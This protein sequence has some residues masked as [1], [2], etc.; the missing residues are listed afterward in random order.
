MKRFYLTESQIENAFI[1]GDEYNHIK[2]VMRMRVGER[3]IAVGDATCDY[4]FEIKEMGKTSARL[5]FIE[6][7]EN[8]S[9]PKINIMVVQALAKGDKL[10]LVTEK[11]TELGATSI[12][13]IYLKNCDVKEGSGKLARLARIA[14][15]ATKQCGRSKPLEVLECVNLKGLQQLMGQFDLVVL[16]NEREDTKPLIEVLTENKNAKSIMIIV[17][18]EGGFCEEEINAMVDSGAKSVTL[19][20]RILRT[21]TAG[22]YMLSVINEIFNN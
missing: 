4:I 15:S 11:A 7:Y 18:P 10:D 1:D 21:E 20:R 22:L 17:G 6:K 14:I 5:N 2:N 12:C 19:G 13:P 8:K 9:N 3:F 16:A